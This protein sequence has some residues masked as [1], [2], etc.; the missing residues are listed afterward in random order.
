MEN[1]LG[2]RDANGIP[3]PMTVEIRPLP[4]TLR[5]RQLKLS[6]IYRCPFASSS[7][8]AGLRIDASTAGPPSPEY[9]PVPVPATVTMMPSTPILRMRWLLLSVRYRLPSGASLRLW[10]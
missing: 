6:E 8:P 1:L 7:R 3:V 2:P 5:T 10:M 9:Q 4:S